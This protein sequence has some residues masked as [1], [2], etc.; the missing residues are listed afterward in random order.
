MKH[1]VILRAFKIVESQKYF[2]SNPIKWFC[3]PLDWHPYSAMD[4]FFY[5]L[6][7]HIV[8]SLLLLPFV[9]ILGT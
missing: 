8:F 4:F 2:N 5:K 9:F 1:V 6:L 3:Y 7:T